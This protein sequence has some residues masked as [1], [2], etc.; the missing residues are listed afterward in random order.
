[1]RWFS[2]CF[3]Q[4]TYRTFIPPGETWVNWKVMIYVSHPVG[5]NQQQLSGYHSP[6][7]VIDWALTLHSPTSQNLILRN[8][9]WNFCHLVQGPLRVSWT[10]DLFSPTLNNLSRLLCLPADNDASQAGGIACAP[11]LQFVTLNI[12]FGSCCP[13]LSTVLSGRLWNF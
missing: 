12:S 4:N 6:L 11:L 9:F 7:Q 8:S 2:R 5:L 3:M 1:M 13:L 10:L